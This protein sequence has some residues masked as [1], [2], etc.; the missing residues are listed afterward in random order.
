MLLVSGWTVANDVTTHCHNDKML[1]CIGTHIPYCAGCPS[2]SPKHMARS[3]SPSYSI[4]DIA[5]LQLSSSEWAMYASRL[6][7]L[8][9]GKPSLTGRGGGHTVRESQIK[10]VLRTRD[11][12]TYKMSDSSAPNDI[13]SAWTLQ[14]WKQGIK[15]LN[16]A[17]E[18]SNKETLEPTKLTTLAGEQYYTSCPLL[19][20]GNRIEHH[21]R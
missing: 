10:G 8:P 3:A 20:F 17:S 18:I 12:T 9:P 14:W 5:N 21:R 4:P 1:P 2:A 16:P 11:C 6:G 15:N 7:P 13:L 19:L